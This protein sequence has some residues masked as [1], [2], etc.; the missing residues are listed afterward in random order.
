M[1]YASVCMVTD[2]DAWRPHEAGVDVGAVLEVMHRNTDRARAL[3]THFVAA[4]AGMPRLPS[5]IDTVLA[6]SVIT[7]PERR[8]PAMLDRLAPLFA[9]RG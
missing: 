4:L 7:A 8:D 2:Y 5:P 3:V 6:M 9:A 1:P